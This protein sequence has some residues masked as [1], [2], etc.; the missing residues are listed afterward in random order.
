[1]RNAIDLN[2]NV[3]LRDIWNSGVAKGKAQALMSLLQG[4]FNRVPR[5]A[6]ERIAK[7]PPGRIERWA[8]KTLTAGTIEGVLGRR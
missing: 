1:L 8:I 2:D 3:I 4:K 7:A 5:W 6:Q